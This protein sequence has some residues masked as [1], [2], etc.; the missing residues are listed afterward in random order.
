MFRKIAL[1]LLSAAFVF[2]LGIGAPNHAEAS[3]YSQFFTSIKSVQYGSITYGSASATATVSSVNTAKAVLSFLGYNTDVIATDGQTGY[4]PNI[5]L[6]NATT[7]T[8]TTRTNTGASKTV[9]FVLT[10]FY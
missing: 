3:T 10:E 7:V 1:G 2:A 5:T 8:S 4:V 9:T 6:T